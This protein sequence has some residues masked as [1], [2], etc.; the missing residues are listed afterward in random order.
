MSNSLS[1][2]VGGAPEGVDHRLFVLEQAGLFNP[3][4]PGKIYVYR[5]NP[6]LY[7]AVVAVRWELQRSMTMS[8]N[9]ALGAAAVMANAEWH[10]AL[11]R[12]FASSEKS[13][14]L[15]QAYEQILEGLEDWEC[16]AEDPGL[17]DRLISRLHAAIGAESDDE[18][19]PQPLSPEDRLAKLMAFL[20]K[21]VR[22]REREWEED[23][24]EVKW[25]NARTKA[26]LKSLGLSKAKAEAL[27][28]EHLEAVRQARQ[29]ARRQEQEKTAS[30]GSETGGK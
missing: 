10:S 11:E 28:R 30:I 29:E 1:D 18:P 25:R 3:Q 14:K 13:C 5:V 19:I 9:D 15:R 21:Q 23:R 7:K 6:E 16:P 17:R 24:K 12:H 22:D 20:Q 27:K 26:I 2:F 4:E 8:V